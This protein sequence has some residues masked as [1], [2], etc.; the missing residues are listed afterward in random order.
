MVRLHLLPS[1]RSVGW[2][3]ANEI[4]SRRGADGG[5]SGAGALASTGQSVKDSLEIEYLD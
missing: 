1:V 5:A 3:V 4:F 2:S